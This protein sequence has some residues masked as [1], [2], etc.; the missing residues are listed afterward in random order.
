[1]NRAYDGR[2]QDSQ[3]PAARPS[4]GRQPLRR[5]QPRSASENRRACRGDWRAGDPDCERCD[6][7]T[8]RD[9]RA[10]TLGDLKNEHGCP[11]FGNFDPTGRHCKTCIC[12]DR[13]DCISEAERRARTA[14]AAVAKT[15]DSAQTRG[16]IEHA[17]KLQAL[18][19]AESRRMFD[20]P[21]HS[22]DIQRRLMIPHCISFFEAGFGTLEICADCQHVTACKL[23][24]EGAKKEL[25]I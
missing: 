20:R 17:K 4:T 9:C 5:S 2:S 12:W 3:S 18:M 15:P 23:R 19:D 22:L 11:Q 13:P 25:Q 16:D 6:W 24:T 1:M 8:Q 7:Q 10:E 14:A 21:L